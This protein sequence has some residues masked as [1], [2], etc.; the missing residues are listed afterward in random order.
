MH[1]FARRL[2]SLQ[3]EEGEPTLDAMGGAVAVV[4]WPGGDGCSQRQ[5]R[6]T[7]RR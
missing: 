6:E 2:A 4:E 1:G 3:P 7:H 5:R